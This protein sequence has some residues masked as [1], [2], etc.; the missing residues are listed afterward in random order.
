MPADTRRCWDAFGQ[1]AL[2]ADARRLTRNLSLLR[3]QE[4]EPETVAA[5]RELR[6]ALQ[7]LDLPERCEG[8]ENPAEHYDEDCVPLCCEC[9]QHLCEETQR[10]FDP[11]DPDPRPL[12]VRPT[13]AE[14]LAKV[15]ASIGPD[16]DMDKHLRMVRGEDSWP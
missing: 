10:E 13:M 6:L 7:G 4:L 15:Q 11:Y 1:S 8:C 9:W 3:G 12:E 2:A 14:S 5:L 16:Y